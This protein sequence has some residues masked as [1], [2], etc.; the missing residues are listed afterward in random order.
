MM[1]GLAAKGSSMLVKIFHLITSLAAAQT[2][3]HGMQE[4]VQVA[5][6]RSAYFAAA[7]LLAFAAAGFLLA[8]L[9]LWLASLHGAVTADLVVG[10]GLLAIGL[11]I[12]G[13]GINTGKHR[14]E[15]APSGFPGDAAAPIGEL[16]GELEANLKDDGSS[17]KALAA[18][19]LAGVLIARLLWK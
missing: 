14:Q 1:H 18:A 6:R 2:A 10:G 4:K 15:S 7:A 9:W 12:L 8:A 17:L 11:V 5:A 3:V 19:V 16:L 13:I